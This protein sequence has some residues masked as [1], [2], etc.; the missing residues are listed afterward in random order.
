MSEPEPIASPIGVLSPTVAARLV[1]RSTLE[2]GGGRT[3]AY[4]ET[5]AGPPVV[6]I[7]GTLMSLEDMWLGPV[8]MLAGQFRVIAVD[9]PGHGFSRRSGPADAH[10]WRQAAL[11]RDGIAALGLERPVIVGHSFGAAVA[12]AYG[13]QFPDTIAGVVALAPICFPEPRLEHL[14][15]GPR[16]VPGGNWLSGLLERSSDP[17]LLPLLWNAMFLPGTMP[18]AYAEAYPFGLAGNAEQL[19]AEGEDAAGLLAGL[20]RSALAYHTCRVPVRI[21]GGDSDIVVSTPRHGLWA[22]HR[23]PGAHFS[24]LARTGHMLHHQHPEA[25]LAATRAIVGQGHE[26]A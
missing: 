21:L 11:I 23:I 22:S 7:H 24:G 9:R 5:G 13:L 8:P 25:V 18:Q 6:V 3:L 20:I 12:L 15:F 17:A 14:L 4:A 19:V 10:S 26:K 1:P 16:A 2:L